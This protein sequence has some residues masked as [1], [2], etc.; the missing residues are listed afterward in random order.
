MLPP[1]AQIISADDHIVEPPHVWQDRLPQR[2]RAEGPR[3]VRDDQGE[4]LWVYAGRTYPQS[5]IAA[6]AG[7]PLATWRRRPF[8]FDE[9]RPGCYDP[10]ARLED[11]DTDGVSIQTNGPSFP[12][13]GGTVFLEGEDRRLALACVR[14]YNDFCVDE[15]CAAAPERFLPVVILPIWDVE[16]SVSELERTLALGAKMVSFVEDP[17]PLGL[18]SFYTDHWDPL[19]AVA[20]EAGIPLSL[21]F[22]SSGRVAFD[23]PGA[24]NVVMQ[25]LLGCN[26]MAALTDLVY[27]PLLERFPRLKFVMSESGIGWVPYLIERLDQMW[28]EHRHYQ[29]ISFDR[30]PSDVYRRH[31]W[32]CTILTEEFGMSVHEAV[33]TDRILIESDYPHADSRWPHT[34]QRAAEL[35]ATVADDD[36][37][38]IAEL[39][40]RTVFGLGP[41]DRDSATVGP[42]RD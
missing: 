13:L 23:D 10:R 40:A 7:R 18:P 24:P 14:A 4:D 15:W 31:F 33:G 38:Q 12:R 25:S 30:R 37:R 16:L 29:P 2:M 8:S 20:Q 6:V 27:S 5:L 9:I 41:P 26:S 19:F 1:D 3:V 21:H 34:R 39:N 11:M 35:L 42:A 28:F 22:G 36:A 17:V 32:M